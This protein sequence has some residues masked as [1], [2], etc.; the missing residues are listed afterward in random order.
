MELDLGEA[1]RQM[2]GLPFVFA[3]WMARADSDL[4]ALPSILS[5]CRDLNRYR[6]SEI[7]ASHAVPSGWPEDLARRYLGEIL[8]Y[9]IGSRELEAIELFWQR[10]HALGLIE[11]VRPMRLYDNSQF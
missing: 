7:A 8:R 3:C 1:W 11:R 4:G 6:S 9:E 10:C 2:T 5:R